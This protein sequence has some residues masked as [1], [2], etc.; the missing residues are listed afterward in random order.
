VHA[1]LEAGSVTDEMKSEPRSLAFGAD[2]RQ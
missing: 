1:L 2:S